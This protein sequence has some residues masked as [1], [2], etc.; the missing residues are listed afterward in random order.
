[1]ITKDM[2]VSELLEQYPQAMDV[3]LKTSA[4]FQKLKNPLLRRFVAPRASIEDAA[5][6]GGVELSTLLADLNAA[7]GLQCEPELAVLNNAVPSLTPKPAVITNAPREK[8]ID[9][10]VREDIS[11]NN[12]PFKKIMGAVKQMGDGDILHLINV[13]EPVPLYGVLGRRGLAHWAEC[14]DGVWHIYF[15]AGAETGAEAPPETPAAAA[16]QEK[17][18]ELD[19]A[20]LEPPEPMMKILASL[21]RIDAHTVMVVH[22]HREPL[23]LYDKLA[24]RG[25]VWTTTKRSENEFR[26]EIRMKA[27]A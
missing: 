21:P 18:I 5:R 25:Y 22:H 14:I 8:I 12:D 17:I 10:D 7:C 1:M 23:M 15:F 11:Q 20:G 27:D 9:L 2:R 26:I 3:L 24:E 13:F 4:H 6:V 16:A 19:V